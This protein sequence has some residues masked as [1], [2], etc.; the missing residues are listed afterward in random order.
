MRKGQAV[1]EFK[2]EFHQEMDERGGFFALDLL[3]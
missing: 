2:E 1:D 3:D